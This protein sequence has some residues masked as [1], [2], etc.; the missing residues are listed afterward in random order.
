MATFGKFSDSGEY[1]WFVADPGNEQYELVKNIINSQNYVAEYR[2]DH[3]RVE[4][5]SIL[6]RGRDAWDVALNTVN[7]GKFNL[8][9][10]SIGI[11]TG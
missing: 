7:I 5:E 10:A 2:L 3:H 8:G 1:V 4:E 11:C 6:A 9:W